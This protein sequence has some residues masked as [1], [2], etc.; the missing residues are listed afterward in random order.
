MSFL[1]TRSLDVKLKDLN[2]GFQ[3]RRHLRLGKLSVFHMGIYVSMLN[4]S[5]KHV[6]VHQATLTKRGILE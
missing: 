6:E 3:R 4:T 2:R 5:Q 1:R